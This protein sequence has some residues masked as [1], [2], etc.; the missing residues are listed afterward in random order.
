MHEVVKALLIAILLVL[1]IIY[2][3][4]GNLRAT[5]VPAV[6]VPVSIIATFMVMS[7][8]GYT[9]NTLTLLGLVLAVGLVV[10]DSIIVLENIYR[11]IERGEKPLLAALEGSREI[12]FA[13][14]A[15]TLVLV[16]VFVPL[17]FIQGDI[18]RLFNEF[19]ITLAAAVL[20]SSLVALTL[21][22][23]MSSRIFREDERRAGL[24][25]SSTSSSADVR[26]YR[27]S[28]SVRAAAARLAGSLVV[29]VL[30]AV[31]IVVLPSEYAPG[32]PRHLLRCP[33]CPGAVSVHGPLRAQAKAI[34][35]RDRAR[36]RAADSFAPARE[37]RR[38][39]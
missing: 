28:W 20:F 13:V 9:V 22:P 14:I 4:L 1:V 33:A 36:A 30:A 8:L 39:R 17:S 21:S 12:G 2:A 16:A 6:V 31:I 11:R 34:S 37:L 26:A 15:T 10:D 25:A 35:W 3:F 29:S 19:G 27:S 23:M 32:R 38:I 5:L 24:T 18:G 7:A